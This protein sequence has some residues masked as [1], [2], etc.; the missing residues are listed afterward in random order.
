M[1]ESV[2]DTHSVDTCGSKTAPGPRPPA[3]ASELTGEGAVWSVD[4]AAWLYKIRVCRF[5]RYTLTAWRRHVH[6]FRQAPWDFARLRAAPKVMRNQC[7][8]ERISSTYGVW[9]E[10]SVPHPLFSDA[11]GVVFRCWVPTSR[12]RARLTLRSPPTRTRRALFGRH[13]AAD[14]TCGNWVG[15]LPNWSLNFHG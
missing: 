2:V 3:G 14:G 8:Y 15:H 10:K 7:A 9:P 6:R 11:V 4:P 12:C 5:F 1:L 13:A